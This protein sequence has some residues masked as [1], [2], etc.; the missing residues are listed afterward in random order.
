MN[1][2]AAASSSTAVATRASGALANVTAEQVFV[3]VYVHGQLF[4]IAVDRVQDILI[5]EKV[6]RIPLAPPEVA[7][8]INLRG[9]IV[10]VIDVR[11]RLGLPP[12]KNQK[13]VMCVTVEEGN[14]LYS[15]MVDSVGNV[16]SLSVDAIEPNP[17]TLDPRW[18]GISQ[19]VVRLDGEL[20]VVM[21]VDAFLS[22]GT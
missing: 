20:M 21:D 5:P 8:A 18:R 4:G 19:G 7:G 1:Q 16:H 22:F 9:R 17:S 15:L 6:A 2:V 13:K 14:E 3:T 10:T 12:P 11:K